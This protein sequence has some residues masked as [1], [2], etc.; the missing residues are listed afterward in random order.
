MVKSCVRFFVALPG[1]VSLCL[2]SAAGISSA[3]ETEPEIP[4]IESVEILE[5]QPQESD[6]AVIWFDDFDGPVKNYT[7]SSGE[8]DSKTKFGPGGKSMK[9]FYATGKQGEGNRKVFFGDSPYGNV[10]KPGRRF[11]E[12]Y[13]RIYVKHQAGWTG[14]GPAKMSRATSIVS[15]AWN[16]AMIAHVWSSGE[17]LT[18]DPASGV[19]AGSNQVIT[20]KYNDFDHLRWLGNKPVSEMKI[21]STEESGWWVCVEARAKLNTP[22]KSDGENQLWIDGRLECERTGLDWIGSYTGHGINA[23]FLEAYWN[24]GSP[25][26]QSRWYDNFVISPHRIGPVVTSVNPVLYKTEYR[27]P[28]TQQA[29]EVELASDR[30]GNHVVWR[31]GTITAGDSVRVD[32]ASGTFAGSLAGRVSLAEGTKYYTRVR[33]QSGAGVW[34]D[35][36]RWHQEFLTGGEAG[37]AW[38]RG[39]INGDSA[40]S[41]MDAV[42]LLLIQRTNPEDTRADYNRDGEISIADILG[43]LTDM[44]GWISGN[45]QVLA[46]VED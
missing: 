21:S 14:G 45:L 41:I 24:N 16:Q 28:D 7:E 3:Q 10:V 40:V 32:Q 13:W 8:L 18:L 29:W 1:L 44:I 6:T 31:S 5:V 43:L 36:S 34:S 9:C 35:W 30:E 25:V 27:G 11:D 4:R 15:S 46:S 23:V 2:A 33:Q 42:C 38:K 20:A 12:I 22:G 17:S 26:D 37:Q 19:P 39:D